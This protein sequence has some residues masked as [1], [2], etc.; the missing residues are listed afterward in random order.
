MINAAESMVATLKSCLTPTVIFC[1]L[2]L[3]IAIIYITSSLNKH[4]IFGDHED[5]SRPQLFQ[6]PSPLEEVESINLPVYRSE[7]PDRFG[8]ATVPQE[9][10][11]QQK[12]EAEVEI[13]KH[14][15]Y[16]E[17][18]HMTRSMSDACVKAPAKRELKKSASEKAFMAELEEEADRQWPATA[19]ETKKLRETVSDGENEDVDAKADDF[20]NRFRQ[21]L[22]L[23]RL[24]SILMY[25]KMLD[26]RI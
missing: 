16:A 22:K 7:Q 2:N 15:V 13:M 12:Y 5:N 18:S 9:P 11:H 24:D 20:I 21:Q 17:E 8:D 3:T 19:R 25:K 10:T 6:V 23:Q 4:L 26:R 1:I 14:C